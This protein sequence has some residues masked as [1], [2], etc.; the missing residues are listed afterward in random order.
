MYDSC[1][2]PRVAVLAAEAPLLGRPTF[3]SCLTWQSATAGLDAC[4]SAPVLG[5]GLHMLGQPREQ[6]SQGFWDGKP[7][8]RGEEG[9]D[10]F[11]KQLLSPQTQFT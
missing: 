6:K 2:T 3:M 8:L 10:F 1:R 5:S 7:G 9:E 11:V 4:I